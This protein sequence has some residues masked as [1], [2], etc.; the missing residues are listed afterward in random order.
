MWPSARSRSIDSSGYRQMARSGPPWY[1]KRCASPSRP[2][3]VT[4]D[5][6]TAVF[7]TPPRDTLIW[8]ILAFS[9]D[10]L[11]VN[12][13]CVDCTRIAR[14]AAGAPDHPLDAGFQHLLAAL[15]QNPVVIGDDPAIGLLRFA[16]VRD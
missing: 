13:R 10:P 1:L 11:S 5:V 4:R 9:P 14:S 7:G 2:S 8:T 15:I 3:L 12:F 6:G 16:L